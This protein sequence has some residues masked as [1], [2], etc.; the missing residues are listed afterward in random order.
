MLTVFLAL[1]T[2]FGFGMLLWLLYGWCLFPVDCP[3]TMTLEAKGSGIRA[4]RCL[5]GL[6][7]LISTGLLHGSILVQDCGLTPEER[8]RL[9]C[10]TD[11][12]PGVR[13]TPPPGLFPDKIDAKEVDLPCQAAQTRQ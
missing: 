9:L 2:A 4:E 11:T 1:G 5:Q 3:V 6:C 10:F 13:L 8:D 12:H 7:W